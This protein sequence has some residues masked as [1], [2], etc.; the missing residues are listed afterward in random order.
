MT[1]LQNKGVKIL[2]WQFF[3]LIRGYDLE[4]QI[5]IL[6]IK[7]KFVKYMHK[8]VL[9]NLRNIFFHTKD[10]VLKIDDGSTRVG[11]LNFLLG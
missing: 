8:G 6:M 10:M 4:L 9:A 1:T 2:I 11:L 7:I 5:T 3:H